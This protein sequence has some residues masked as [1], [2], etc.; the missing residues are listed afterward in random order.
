LAQR[1]SRHIQPPSGPE[2]AF[3]QALREIRTS[4]KLS[5]E[6]LALESDFDRTYVSLLERGLQ[7]PTVRTI[8]KLA[9]TLDVMPSLMIRRMERILNFPIGLKGN[10]KPKR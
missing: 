10:V 2:K 7:S 5:Q 8:V 3:G 9:A 1:N 6:Q 4:R